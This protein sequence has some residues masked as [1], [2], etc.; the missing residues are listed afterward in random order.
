MCDSVQGYSDMPERDASGGFRRIE[1]SKTTSLQPDKEAYICTI[2]SI[3]D[4]NWCGTM[5][6]V[7]KHTRNE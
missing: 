5:S 1:R 2:I 7:S 6:G 3:Y 4:N